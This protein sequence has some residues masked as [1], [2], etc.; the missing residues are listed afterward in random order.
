MSQIVNH[1]K[2]TINILKLTLSINKI[3][4]KNKKTQSSANFFYMKRMKRVWHN[5]CPMNSYKASTLFIN[6]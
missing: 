1:K 4:S 5:I 2:L 6:Y 3:N